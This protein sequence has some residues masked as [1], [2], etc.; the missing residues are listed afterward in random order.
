MTEVGEDDIGEFGVGVQA[1]ED[2]AGFDIAMADT[3]AIA[4]AAPG[5]ETS[6]QEFEGGSELLVGLPDEEFRQQDSFFSVPVDELVQVAPGAEFEMI[7]GAFG[8]VR[9]K[10]VETDDVVVAVWEDILEYG[11][12]DRFGVDGPSV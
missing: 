6:V 11:G 9:L 7:A 5:V 12:F 10:G 1:E 4:I 8:L 3:A 2:V